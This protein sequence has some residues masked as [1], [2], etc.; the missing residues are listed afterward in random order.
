MSSIID[1]MTPMQHDR[2]VS[3]KV[4]D[5]LGMNVVVKA[6]SMKRAR[7]G[8]IIGIEYGGAQVRM[9]KPPYEPLYALWEYIYVPK[10]KPSDTTE[11]TK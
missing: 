7:R 8:I 2:A 9:A 5:L 6:R 10:K 4:V 3:E 1:D 11:N